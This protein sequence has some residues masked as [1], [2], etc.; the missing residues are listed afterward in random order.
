MNGS[1]VQLVRIRA[2]HACGRGF[3]SRPDRKKPS[4]S[5][6]KAFSFLWKITTYIFCKAM[7][8]GPFIKVTLLI[9]CDDWSIIILVLV[10]ILQISCP[11]NLYM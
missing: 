8:M 1:V 5:I 4:H 2:C 3:E 7:W 11:G 6:G 10:G 9:I